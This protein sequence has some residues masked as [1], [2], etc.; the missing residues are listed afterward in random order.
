MKI[1][2]QNE[3]FVV[4][5]KPPLMLSVP[6]RL[7]KKD[8]RPCAGLLLQELLRTTVYP[9]HRLDEGASGLLLFALNPE[10]HRFGNH[11][12]QASLVG[13][14]YQAV[15]EYDSATDLRSGQ[16]FRWESLL[17]KGKKRAFQ[18]PHGKQC[19]TEAKILAIFQTPPR[20]LWSLHPQTGRPHQLRFE[21]STHGYPIL[22]D[23]LYGA[24]Q[25]WKDG[26]I[27]LRC[28]VLKFPGNSL[29]LPANINIAGLQI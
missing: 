29:G 19:L 28:C 6:S 17:A 11:L 21:L 16:S 13:K 12:F 27:A 22:G 1:V 2:W 24:K 5:D 20:A 9:T 15:S 10:A 7:G 3:H 4:I 18:A 14:E 8:E 25:S 26:G 23:T